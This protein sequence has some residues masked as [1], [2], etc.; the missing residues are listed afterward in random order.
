MT[1]NLKIAQGQFKIFNKEPE[2]N[3]EKIKDFII[4]ASNEN[5]DLIMFPESAYTGCILPAI[6][7]QKLSETKNGFLYHK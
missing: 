3:L 7:L 1:R 2:K 6:E 5:C 4:K